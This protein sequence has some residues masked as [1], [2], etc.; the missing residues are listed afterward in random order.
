[1]EQDQCIR[2]LVEMT[3]EVCCLTLA[4]DI[5]V[6]GQNYHELLQFRKYFLKYNKIVDFYSLENFLWLIKVL[7]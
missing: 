7:L 4:N 1:M 2:A 3:C 5:H 6:S